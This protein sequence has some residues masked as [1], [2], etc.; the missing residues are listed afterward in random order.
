MEKVILDHYLNLKGKD[1]NPLIS[2]FGKVPN[3]VF[4]KSENIFSGNAKYVNCKFEKYMMI[5][6]FVEG[7]HFKSYSDGT[8]KSFINYQ[9]GKIEGKSLKWYFNGRME[10]RE[11][12]KNGILRL[13]ETWYLTGQMDERIQYRDGKEDGETIKYFEDGKINKIGSYRE[14]KKDGLW[15]EYYKFEKPKSQGYYK[16]GKK[17][18]SWKNWDVDGTLTITNYFGGKRLN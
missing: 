5:D 14:G 15:E 8:K 12:Y 3:F 1:N 18:G 11:E 13:R 16:Y 9:N 10:R 6:G 2:L 4:D 7:V 17:D